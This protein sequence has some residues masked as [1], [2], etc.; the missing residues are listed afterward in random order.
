M[1][2]NIAVGRSVS[3]RPTNSL[4]NELRNLSV[5]SSHCSQPDTLPSPEDFKK[6]ASKVAVN[7]NYAYSEDEMECGEDS[8]TPGTPPPILKDTAGGINLHRNPLFDFKVVQ[9]AVQ[10]EKWRV[11]ESGEE[12]NVHCAKVPGA[13]RTVFIPHYY[14]CVN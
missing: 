1:Y 8:D 4:S 11:D 6:T 12:E 10:L 13:P 7:V 2:R 14:T 9:T 3:D 5:S